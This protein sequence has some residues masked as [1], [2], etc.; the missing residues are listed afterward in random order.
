MAIAQEDIG[1]LT[2]ILGMCEE[3]YY[4]AEDEQFL[5]FTEPKNLFRNC[6]STQKTLTLQQD[7]FLQSTEST[8]RVSSTYDYIPSV[9]NFCMTCKQIHKSFSFPLL[10]GSGPVIHP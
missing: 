2:Y 4:H 10:S 1:T 5:S 9:I 7:F 6:S 8:I 3:E